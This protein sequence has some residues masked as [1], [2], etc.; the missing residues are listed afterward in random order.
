MSGNG[1]VSWSMWA[2]HLQS[3]FGSLFLLFIQNWNSICIQ[4]PFAVHFHMC[5]HLCCDILDFANLSFL[6]FCRNLVMKSGLTCPLVIWPKL[7][8]T[9]GC[10]S[11]ENMTFV[12]MQKCLTT[13]FVLSKN[14][15]CIYNTCKVVHLVMV[16]IGMNC[17]WGGPEG[18]VILLDLP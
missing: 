6:F 15:H 10:N 13:T 17:C 8:I 1:E 5:F 14:L 12:Y 4:V 11:W 7:C 18:Q 16:L 3:S 9:F 2:C